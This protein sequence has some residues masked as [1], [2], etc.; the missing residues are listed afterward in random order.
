MLRTR[1]ERIHAE[2]FGLHGQEGLDLMGRSFGFDRL[3]LLDAGEPVTV[4]GW[5]INIPA[6]HDRYL[7]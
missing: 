7:I 2:L 5:E 6:D 1:L 4:Y 3:A